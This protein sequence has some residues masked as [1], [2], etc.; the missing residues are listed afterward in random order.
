M[1]IAEVV[2]DLQQHGVE[3]LVRDGE[4]LYR[5]RTVPQDVR[6]R[7]TSYKA[8]LAAWI[9]PGWPANAPKPDWWIELAAGFPIGTFTQARPQQCGDPS[10]RFGVAVEW[11]DSEDGKLRWSCP[12]CGL[13]SETTP[14]DTCTIG[15]HCLSSGDAEETSD[16]HRTNPEGPRGVWGKPI[17]RQQGNGNQ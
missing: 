15:K 2:A 6:E 9:I 11:R 5:P 14:I 12:K 10:C 16:D 3:W 1:R 8:A 13:S 4:L 7:I 17:L